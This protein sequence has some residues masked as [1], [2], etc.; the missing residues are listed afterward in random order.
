MELLTAQMTLMNRNASTFALITI[1]CY[2]RELIVIALV[3]PASALVMTSTSNAVMAA[4]SHG[5]VFAMVYPIAQD[6]MMKN[7]ASFTM[8]LTEFG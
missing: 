7:F 4:V 5:H 8:T 3:C 1:F 6:K 2:N